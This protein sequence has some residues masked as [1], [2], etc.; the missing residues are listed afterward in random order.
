MKRTHIATLAVFTLLTVGVARSRAEDQAPAAA[1]AASAPKAAEPVFGTTAGGC[2]PD[3][4]CCGH[5]ACAH[6]ATE[7][8]K[9][10]NGAAETTGSNADSTGGGCPCAKMKKK[11]M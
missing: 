4:S 2:M 7:A 5:G 3:G 1:P 9:A 8:G 11:A 6:A 10:A